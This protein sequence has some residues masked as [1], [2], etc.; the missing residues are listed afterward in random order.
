MLPSP[1]NARSIS[2]DA[3]NDELA[4]IGGDGATKRTLGDDL[5]TEHSSSQVILPPFA[6]YHAGKPNHNLLSAHDVSQPSTLIK[7]FNAYL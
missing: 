6:L 1:T 4:S 5:F 7:K 2:P 3:I